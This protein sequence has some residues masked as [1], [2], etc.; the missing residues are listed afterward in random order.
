[1]LHTR[2]WATFTTA[3]ICRTAYDG[4]APCS[5]YI[6]LPGYQGLYFQ[7]AGVNIRTEDFAF[8]AQSYR[9]NM[10]ILAPQLD[11]WG[12]TSAEKTI[13]LTEYFLDH[14]AIDRDQVFISGYYGGGETLSLVLDKRRSF[15]P[16]RCCAVPGGTEDLRRS[17]G[18][19]PLFISSSEKMM[20]T[21]GRALPPGLPEI[22][23]IYEAAGL[24]GEAIDRLVRL[25]VKSASYFAAG[26]V[27]NQHGGG[28]G[29]FARDTD[30]MGWL[31][32]RE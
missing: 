20:N 9:E 32:N 16:L 27:S 11:D 25:D 18:R 14:Y 2:N 26:N 4:S 22:R 28:A 13:R 5:L 7:G 19:R 24:S 17:P 29:L 31:F 30:V 8:E 15:T 10:I 23:G 12:E 21:T 1:M 6:T 3:S